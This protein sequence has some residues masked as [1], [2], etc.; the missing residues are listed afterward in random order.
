MAQSGSST[1]SDEPLY[2]YSDQETSDESVSVNSNMERLFDYEQC[3]DALRGVG[4]PETLT[5]SITAYCAVIRGIRTHYEFAISNAVRELS[6][7]FP[8]I[9]RDRNARLVM[10]DCGLTEEQLADS[11][12][13][14]YCIW[15]PDVASEDTY[16]Q[17]AQHY[18]FLHY[19]VGRAC[20]VAGYHELYKELALLP[21]VSTAEEAR[22][23]DAEGS[24]QIYRSIMASPV[25]YQVMDDLHRSINQRQRHLL[26]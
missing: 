4:I 14:P 21:D 18:P 24:T 2:P 8:E 6:I 16:R 19:Q 20:A 10:S 7:S 17:L 13:V 25:R 11:N 5:T 3:L 9:A 26:F 23:S 12:H 22:E 15:Y 1:T